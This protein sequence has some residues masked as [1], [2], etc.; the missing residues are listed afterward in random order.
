LW[1][2][3]N[4]ALSLYEIELRYLLPLQ[5]RVYDKGIVIVNVRKN[6]SGGP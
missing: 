1:R 5:R 2:I 3:A 4:P 6:Y